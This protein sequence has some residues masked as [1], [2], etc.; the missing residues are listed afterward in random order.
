MA[1]KKNN[2]YN[3]IKDKGFNTR[4]TEEVRQIAAKGG[5]HSGET[6]RRK[7]T[8]KELFLAIGDLPVNEPKI[9]QQLEK[10]GIPKS[11]QTWEMAVAASALAK[12]LKTDNPKMLE[13]VLELLDKGGVNNG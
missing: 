1:I 8:I 5:R 6:R 10:M 13:F 12:A 7:R 9:V 3:N 2:G 4:S 11:E